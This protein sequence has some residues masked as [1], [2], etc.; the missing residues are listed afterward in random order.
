LV[1]VIASIQWWRGKQNFTQEVCC[2]GI[3][4]LGE[5]AVVDL[6]LVELELEGDDTNT[7]SKNYGEIQTTND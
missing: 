7:N 3:A 1:T 4:R 6:K 5:P 2:E